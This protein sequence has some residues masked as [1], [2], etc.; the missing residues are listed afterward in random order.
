MRNTIKRLV[1]NDNETKKRFTDNCCEETSK[2]RI[3]FQLHLFCADSKN[4]SISKTTENSVQITFIGGYKNAV[5]L[6]FL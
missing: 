6:Y 5:K 3:S 4:V 2:H 1:L